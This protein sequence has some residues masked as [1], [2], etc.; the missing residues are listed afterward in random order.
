MPG[1]R[2]PNIHS[3][4]RVDGSEENYD[5]AVSGSSDEA[6]SGTQTRVTNAASGSLASNEW[7]AIPIPGPGATIE[8]YRQCLVLYQLENTN[9]RADL[10]RVQLE[11]GTLKADLRADGLQNRRSSKGK[12]GMPRDDDMGTA[13]RKYAILV[14]PWLQPQ[15]FSLPSRPDIDPQ[16]KIRYTNPGTMQA[17]EAAEVYDIV[18]QRL[19]PILGS[20][21]STYSQQ[22]RTDVQQ[23]RSNALNTALTC[24]GQI[25]NMPQERF[26]RTG[27]YDRA[28]DAAM[29]QFI[30]DEKGLYGLLVPV[31]YPEDDMR[32]NKVFRS[33]YVAKIAKVI[34]F[35]PQSLSR[36]GGAPSGKPP[37]GRA[38]KIKVP[39]DGLI[40]FASVVARYILS[41]DTQLSNESKPGNKTKISYFDDFNNYKH[42]LIFMEESR[43]RKLVE[44]Y[45]EHTFDVTPEPRDTGSATTN[46]IGTR[47]AAF[48][49][50]LQ[51][52][53]EASFIADSDDDAE[54]ADDEDEPDDHIPSSSAL[55]QLTSISSHASSLSN[56]FDGLVIGEQA[57]FVEAAP[58]GSSGHVA[59]AGPS[60]AVAPTGFPSYITSTVPLHVAAS[61][62]PTRVASPGPPGVVGAM[63]G[64]ATPP[65]AAPIPSSSLAP[66]ASPTA[67]TPV[68]TP[69]LPPSLGRELRDRRRPLRPK[70]SAQ[71]RTRVRKWIVSSFSRLQ[72]P[73]R[74]PV[75]L[76]PLTRRPIM[77]VLL[78]ALCER[79]P[80]LRG[81]VDVYLRQGCP[82]V[83]DVA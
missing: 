81:I 20:N 80:R 10:Q 18:P 56:A 15:A 66:V 28:K 73:L 44:F 54:G 23:S 13:A 60:Y 31:L 65:G 50:A 53:N 35:G 71:R 8:Q 75:R 59:L 48:A 72:M 43:K 49:S 30:R 51:A 76:C 21:D 41:P 11:L 27:S 5:L 29:Q 25:F 24:A 37:I 4:S 1:P 77:V 74:L 34:L 69:G 32:I 2:Q 17:A 38:W 12:A 3:S 9:L 22:F 57:A 83:F 70:R 45:L 42:M 33:I 64:V 26:A 14:S 61:A 7:L 67:S 52:V 19:H 78:L 68:V 58:A 63:S 79:E 40:A 16:S 39:T 62:G 82:V 6:Q 47:E 55:S 46:P 36:E